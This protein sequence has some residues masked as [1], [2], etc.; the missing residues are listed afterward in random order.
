MVRQYGGD[1]RNLI[2]DFGEIEEMSQILVY[3]DREV[4]F[5]DLNQ[6][7]VYVSDDPEGSRLGAGIAGG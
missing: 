3:V 4:R 1:Y 5:P 7:L 2:F 6:W